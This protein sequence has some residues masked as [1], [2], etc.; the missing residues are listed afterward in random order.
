MIQDPLEPQL[1]LKQQQ[2]HSVHPQTVLADYQ[3]DC[4]SDLGAFID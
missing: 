1:S 2:K 3:S 4:F